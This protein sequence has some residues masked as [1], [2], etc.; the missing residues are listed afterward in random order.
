MKGDDRG[1]QRSHWAYVGAFMDGLAGAGVRHICFA[2]GSRSTPL[3]MMAARHPAIT[4][5]SHIDERSA[6]FFALGLARGLGEPVALVC[7]SGTA[8]ANFYPAVVEA[9]YS[10]VPL[11][12]LTSDRPHE[13][14]DRGASQTIDQIGMYGP[15]VKWFADMAPSDDDPDMVRYSRTAA[16]RAAATAREAPAGP[17]HL[18]FPFREPLVP[19]PP[20][21]GGEAGPLRA[22]EPARG[23]APGFNGDAAPGAGRANAR[24]PAVHEGHRALPPGAVRRLAEELASV[25]R[26][27]I[28][29][30]PESHAELAEAVT[31]L[32]A[33]LDWPVLADPLSSVRCGRHDLSRIVDAYDAFLRDDA[34]VTSHRPDAVLRF[35]AFPVSKPLLLALNRWAG[36]RHMV[37]DGGGGWREPTGLATD[38]IHADEAGFCAALASALP[39]RPH[40]AVGPWTRA[41]LEANAITRDAIREAL[42][43][44]EG[45]SEP[46]VFAELAHLLPEGAT[47]FVGNSMPVR[48]LDTF[49]PAAPRPLRLLA[50]RGAAGID[51]VVSTALGVAAA[52][53]PPASA[54]SEQPGSPVVLVVGDLSF[55]HD[56]NGLL[57]AKRHGLTMT[58]VLIHNDGGG[59]FSFLPQADHP[60]YFEELFGTPIGLDFRPA[61]EM[62]GGRFIGAT[63]WD[64]FRRGVQ[65]GL[66]GP[67]LTVVEVKTDR[68]GNVGHHRRIWQAVFRALGRARAG[69]GPDP[70]ADG[71][72]GEG[73]A[74]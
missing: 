17:V 33:R 35:G 72:A 10:R 42:A 15:H 63:D 51:G 60:E 27:I 26:G 71:S 5:W 44:D 52:L 47:L 50:N 53:N 57:A 41:W 29:C 67:G 1:V 54:P 46:R 22:G 65:A 36:C 25:Q 19:L 62:Y 3:V 66:A 23:D 49:F 8:A 18:N 20:D 59:I 68:A 56:M 69:S 70:T 21:P 74:G 4:L 38:V 12:V 16:A 28:V 30:G 32:A 61:V 14:R 34:F 45:L 9:F 58:V 55:Y 40:D 73:E 48:D 13:L 24:P 37:V 39:F 43:A 64:T 7:T 2:P 11:V 31:A 6:A